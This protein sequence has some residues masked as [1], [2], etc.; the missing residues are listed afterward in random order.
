MEL[1]IAYSADNNVVVNGL[2]KLLAK[3]QIEVPKPSHEKF[4]LKLRIKLDQNFIPALDTAELIEEYK[5]EKKIPIKAAPAPVAAPKEGEPAPEAPQVEQT[6]ETKIVDKTK[7]TNI[8][9]KFEHHGFSANQLHD[10]HQVENDM[11]TSD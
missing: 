11:F 2:P 1:Q 6:F 5:E 3:Y 7:S 9:F 4:S 8:H 10:F